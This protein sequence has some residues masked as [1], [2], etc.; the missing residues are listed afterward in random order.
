MA[1]SATGS[2]QFERTTVW[3][4]VMR[5]SG[6]R[7]IWYEKSDH[8][9]NRAHL[10][11]IRNV[12][13]RNWVW[14]G[15]NS[16]AFFFHFYLFFYWQMLALPRGSH[17]AA[18]WS[19]TH[20][21]SDSSDQKKSPADGSGRSPSKEILINWRPRRF[22]WKAVLT[23]SLSQN[24]K[25]IG[26]L[27]KTCSQLLGFVFFSKTFIIDFS[28]DEFSH[29]RFFTSKIFLWSDHFECTWVWS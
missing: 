12:F 2:D 21:K 4:M 7:S 20:L 19:E 15:T 26:T 10:G 27:N 1:A 11:L 24:Y 22:L 8:R 13:E 18:F 23:H 29:V 9:W 6:Q 3:T 17:K 14:W 25:L 28:L 5:W 16:S